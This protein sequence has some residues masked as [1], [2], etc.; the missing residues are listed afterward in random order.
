MRRTNGLNVVSFALAF[1]AI[2]LWS[3]TLLFPVR[4]PPASQ[5]PVVSQCGSSVHCVQNPDGTKAWFAIVYQPFVINM[6]VS[7]CEWPLTEIRAMTQFVGNLNDVHESTD[8][9]Y[10]PWY[11]VH[12][13]EIVTMV[14]FI[15]ISFRG[16]DS[17]L[18]HFLPTGYLSSSY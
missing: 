9:A 13:G 5:T 18:F 10:D 11:V 16:K 1:A 4:T 15:C 17:D 3:Y 12:M 14:A 7:G 6:A 8:P 2:A